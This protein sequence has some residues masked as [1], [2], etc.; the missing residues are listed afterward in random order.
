[1]KLKVENNAILTSFHLFYF[2]K[3]TSWTSFL[4]VYFPGI[5]LSE[6][7]WLVLVFFVFWF[8]L[9]MITKVIEG[10]CKK[11]NAHKNARAPW[12]GKCRF[13]IIQLLRELLA[14]TN[15]T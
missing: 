5:F 9:N 6:V 13:P 4:G 8:F 12:C 2:H 1:M 10:C 11:I 14:S 15:H 7:G 3:G